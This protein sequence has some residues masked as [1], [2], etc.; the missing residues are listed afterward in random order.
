MHPSSNNLIKLKERERKIIALKIIINSRKKKLKSE[1]NCKGWNHD[2]AWSNFQNENADWIHNES[3]D[4][5]KIGKRDGAC[6]MC[7]DGAP[8]L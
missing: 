1:T 3:N 8:W 5:I 2:Q 7:G 6:L 4:S